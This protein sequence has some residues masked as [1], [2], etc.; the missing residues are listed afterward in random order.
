MK[1]KPT[2]M[3]LTMIAGWMNRQ[4][5]EIIDYLKAENGILKEEL[6]KATGKKRIQLNDS[7]RRR[8][9]ILGK[10]LGRK[11]LGDVCCAFSPDTLLL[12]HRKLVAR[13]YDGSKNRGKDGRPR[14]SDYLKQLIIDMAKN[15]KHL[16]VRKLHGYLKY[17][18]LKVSPATISRV[19]REHGIDPCP[20]RSEKTT[21]NEFI[22]SHWD[23]LAAIDFFTV[24]ALTLRGLV[25]YM[26]LVVI[27]YKTRKVEIAG[28]IPQADGKWMKQIVRNL[29]DPFDGFLKNKKYLIMD[30]DPLFTSAFRE[31]LK[32]RGVIPLRTTA[33]SPNLSPFVERFIRSIKHECLNKM[34]IFGERHLRYVVSEYIDFYH[35]HRPHQ[36]LDN[37]MIDPLPQGKGTIIC[38]KQLGGLLKSYRRA[39]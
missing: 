22:R 4:Q 1:I 23:S 14:I 19:L 34:L 24:E 21:W 7:Q 17:L 6:L 11:L 20:N 5:Q 15:N 9:A 12:W 31:M 36:G 3:I 18:G 26:V 27:D 30:R 2:T 35:H 39:A 10:K 37:N 29:T 32:D 13:K 16:G 8:L 38:H 33:A 25:K 28:I